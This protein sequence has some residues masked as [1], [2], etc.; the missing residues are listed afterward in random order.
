MEPVWYY[1]VRVGV[2]LELLIWKAKLRPLEAD[3]PVEER[4]VP[5]SNSAAP[6]GAW[7]CTLCCRTTDPR[8][9]A[10]PRWWAGATQAASWKKLSGTDRQEV[11]QGQPLGGRNFMSKAGV[12]GGRTPGSD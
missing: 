10:P 11:R 3:S 7:M 5:S 2:S 6:C 9:G 8:E 4:T 1:G 12:A